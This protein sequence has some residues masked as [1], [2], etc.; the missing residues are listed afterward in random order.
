MKALI[1]LAGLAFVPTANADVSDS[2][3]LSIGGNGIIVGSMTVIGTSAMYGL[4]TSTGIHV[5][6]GAVKLE[7][8]AYVQW[9]DGTTS[10]TSSSGGGVC[11]SCVLL[12]STQSLT[13][14]NTETNQWIHA[15]G[16]TMT[17]SP[18]A[19]TYYGIYGSTIAISTPAYV[20]GGY[21]VIVSTLMTN[22]THYLQ[23]AGFP[24]APGLYDL[25]LTLTFPTTV[26]GTSG[27]FGIRLAIN[28]DLGNS[29]ANTSSDESNGRGLV[30]YYLTGGGCVLNS[31]Q[32]HTAGD[33]VSYRLTIDNNVQSTLTSIYGAWNGH[34]GDGYNS[35]S[36]GCTYTASSTISS[37]T[38]ETTLGVGTFTVNKLKLV[39][40]GD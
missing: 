36:Y 16:S 7:S 17:I 25:Y 20:S 11:S 3:N 32:A 40:L 8:G 22:A 33:I 34:A 18:S 24:K 5:L 35:G 12:N 29:Y 9:S 28:N 37:L 30:G 13:G 19:V 15:A 27:G 10:T 2:G 21:G 1:F 14:Q 31:W 6:N 38:F 39:R 23:I 4:T 26:A